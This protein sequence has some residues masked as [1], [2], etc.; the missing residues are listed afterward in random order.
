MNLVVLSCSHRYVCMHVE[1]SCLHI[2]MNMLLQEFQTHCRDQ[3]TEDLRKKEDIVSLHFG[4]FS[5]VCTR[6]GSPP[7]AL[8]DGELLS[9]GEV[10]SSCELEPATSKAVSHPENMAP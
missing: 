8:A 10:L 7:N 6:L 9:C 5:L 3:R 4:R 1:C 2:S